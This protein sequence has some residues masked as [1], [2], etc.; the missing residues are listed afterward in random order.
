MLFGEGRRW[1]VGIE[2][3]GELFRVIRLE[4]RGGLEFMVFVFF[5]FDLEVVSYWVLGFVRL[6]FLVYMR[7][8]EVK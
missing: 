7:I 8:I 1:V 5:C 2:Y 3:F 6:E 4:E